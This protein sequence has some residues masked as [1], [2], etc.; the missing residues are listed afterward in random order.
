MM[1][2]VPVVLVKQVH[3]QLNVTQRP[4]LMVRPVWQ[5][6]EISQL[7]Y[8]LGGLCSCCSVRASLVMLAQALLVGPC[9]QVH[10]LG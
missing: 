5:T 7:Q 4:F 8:A 9:T 3:F 2:D 1:A 10:G 6:I